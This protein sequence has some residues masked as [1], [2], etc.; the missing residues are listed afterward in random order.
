MWSVRPENASVAGR[1]RRKQEGKAWLEH[2][3]LE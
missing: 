1:D 2:A 3:T